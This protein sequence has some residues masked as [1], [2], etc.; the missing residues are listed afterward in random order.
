MENTEIKPVADKATGEPPDAKGPRDIYKMSRVMYTLEAAFEYFISILVSG[1][2]L[3]KLTTTIGIS[4]SMTAVLSTITS[5]ASSFQLI[6]IFLSQRGGVKRMTAIAT[7]AQFLNAILY[8]IPFLAIGESVM[9]IIFF[10]TILAVYIIKSIISPIKT[11]WFMS[12]VDPMKRGSFTAILQAVSLIGGMA[13]TVIMGI[14]IDKFEA[15]G[16]I[17]GA[18][19]LLS[20]L[21][22]A[23]ATLQL[24]TIVFSKEKP[25][26]NTERKASPFTEVKVL[27]KNK[28]YVRYVIVNVIWA[29]ATNFSL[30]FFGTYQINE[31]GFSMTLISVLSTVLSVVQ[32]ISVAIFGRL[33]MLKPCLTILKIG[34]PVAVASYAVMAFTTP[35]NGIVMFI[36]HRV[37]TLVGSAAITVGGTITYQITSYRERTAA[38]AINSVITGAVGFCVTLAST[39]L[40]DYIKID[41]GSQMFGMT[42]Y[43]QQFLSAITAVIGVLLIIYLYTFFSRAINSDG[44]SLEE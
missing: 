8:L 18:F 1:T 15:D 40:F 19:A 24:L 39:V 3:A 37:L 30:P 35:E 43:A 28:R 32:L 33:S 10:V 29:M 13:F 36:I 9:G 5:L 6:S 22:L 42:V 44:I 17:K 4:D 27:W 26:Q 2:Y 11:N 41:L 14:V 23:L 31:L 21:I 38:L 12:L 20:I 34:Y 7:L 25:T 16:N